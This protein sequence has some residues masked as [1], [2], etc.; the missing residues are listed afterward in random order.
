MLQQRGRV[1]WPPPRLLRHL[2]GEERTQVAAGIFFRGCTA[3]AARPRVAE[4]GWFA[5]KTSQLPYQG[6]VAASVRGKGGLRARMVLRGGLANS[7]D[8]DAT[9]D[10]GDCAV[11]ADGGDCDVTRVRATYLC[12]FQYKGSRKRQTRGS[13]QTCDQAFLVTFWCSCNSLPA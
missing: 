4:S 5:A 2:Q 8:C 7:S 3:P 10:G 6:V 12:C 9:A 13:L 11:V 1:S